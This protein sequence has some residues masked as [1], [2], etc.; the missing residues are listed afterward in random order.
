MQDIGLSEAA[1]DMTQAWEFYRKYFTREPKDD[2]FYHDLAV[3][4]DRM[5]MRTRFGAY[6]LRAAIA[7][8][9]EEDW[10]KKKIGGTA[11]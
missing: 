6:V 5:D 3:E 2:N 10:N 4:S 1:E 8:I 9:S 11:V 7:A